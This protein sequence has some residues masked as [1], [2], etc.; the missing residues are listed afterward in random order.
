MPRELTYAIETRQST[1]PWRCHWRGHG[2]QTAIDGAHGL[3]KERRLLPE[4]GRSIPIYP[5]VRVRQAKRIVLLIGP[6]AE[7]A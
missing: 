1:E 5:Y 3:A 7:R 2:E 6:T 4:L